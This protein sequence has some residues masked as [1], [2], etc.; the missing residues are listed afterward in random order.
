MSLIFVLPADFLTVA[1]VIAVVCFAFG[2]AHLAHLPAPEP[3][4]FC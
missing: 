1:G 3:L 4:S 2:W